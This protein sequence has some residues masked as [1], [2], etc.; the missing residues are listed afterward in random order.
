MSG[1]Y[2]EEELL[3]KLL[4]KKDRAVFEGSL[5]KTE[6]AL[7]QKTA[8]ERTEEEYLRDARKYGWPDYIIERDLK[9]IRRRQARRKALGNLN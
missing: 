8:G 5:D 7:T 1:V 3:P 4:P 2:K 6:G 9:R